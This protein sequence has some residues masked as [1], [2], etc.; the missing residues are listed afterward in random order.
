[1]D[2]FRNPKPRII[3]AVLGIV[4]GAALALAQDAAAQP[5]GP[6]VEIPKPSA[7]QPVDP[8]VDQI[9]TRLEHRE[10]RSIASD[11]SWTTEYAIE[12][13]PLTKLG[14]FWYR[15]DDPVAKFQV[16]LQKKVDGRRVQ[17]LDER[18]LFDG[19]WYVVLNA[20][21]KSVERNQV[22]R[23]D[24]D[25]DPFDVS[26]GQF[27]LPFGQKKERVLRDYVV[28]V[29]PKTNKVPHTDWLIL[30]PLPHS[31]DA[32]N[33]AKVE[34]WIA[35]DQHPFAGLPVKLRVTRKDPNGN[36]SLI[37]AEFDDIELNGRIGDDKFVITTPAGYAESVNPLPGPRTNIKLGADS[38]EAPAQRP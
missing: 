20:A 13:E 18:H 33:V 10:I 37:T 21:T 7:S 19:G 27:P 1:M 22:R 35:D 15:H 6:Q 9:L 5:A 2:R 32:D 26:D 23:P 14:K 36:L 8:R 38:A 12:G 16:H 25:Y 34:F 24:D 11:V 30:T 28:V 31:R 3:L 4:A 29:S 17:P